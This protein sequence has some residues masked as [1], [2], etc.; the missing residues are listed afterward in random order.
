MRPILWMGKLRL[1]PFA[2][3]VGK[4]VVEPAAADSH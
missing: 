4:E 3:P 2:E 1:K